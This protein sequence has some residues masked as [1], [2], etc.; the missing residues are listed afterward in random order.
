MSPRPL[1][2]KSLKSKDPHKIG[3]GERFVGHIIEVVKAAE[4][5][6]DARGAE[7]LAAMGLPASQLPRLKFLVVMAA[8]IHDWGKSSDHFQGMLW[9]TRT[10]RQLVRHEALSFL[11]ALDDD[12]PLKAWLQPCF[13]DEV[14]YRIAAIAAAGHHRKFTDRTFALENAGAGD[15]IT[16]LL[17]HKNFASML[18]FGKTLGLVNIPVPT[19]DWELRDDVFAP[20]QMRLEEVREDAEAVIPQ[21]DYRLLGLVKAMVICA[22]VAGSMM[23]EEHLYSNDL[24]E[25]LA[26]RATAAQLKNIAQTKLSG[27]QPHAFQAALAEMKAPISMVQ[28]GCGSGKTVGAYLWAAQHAG[29]QIWFTYPTTGTATEGYRGYLFEPDIDAELIHGRA[30]VDR[31]L[32]ELTEDLDDDDNRGQVRRDALDAWGRM[33]VACTVDTVLGLIQNQRK[34]LYNWPGIAHSAII[35]DEIHAYDDRL[36]GALLRF[37]QACPGIPALLMT[38]SLPTARLSA[39]QTVSQEVHGLKLPILDGPTHLEALPRYVLQADADPM[40]AA[41]DCLG[42]GGKVL[43][44]CNTVGRCRAA[45]DQASGQGWPALCYHSRFRYED[46]VARHSDVVGSFEKQAAVIAVT[47]QVCEMSLD[48][49]ADL[50]V[51][52]LA[53]IPA[54]IQRLGRLN[55]KATPGCSP[56]P[57]IVIEPDNRLPYAEDQLAEARV[58]VAALGGRVVS[59]KDLIDA[60]SQSNAPVPP[61]ESAWLDLVSKTE[62]GNLRESSPSLTVLLRDDLKRVQKHRLSP[63]RFALPMSLPRG[64]NW[65]KWPAHNNIPSPP[66]DLIEYDPLRGAQWRK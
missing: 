65:R 33:A 55:R 6:V 26:Q 12:S 34:G 2:A 60:W 36:F 35:F 5:L 42:Q 52:E 39:L 54:L 45:F 62:I 38:A 15:S 4:M 59:Q 63:T 7:S 24:S 40:S 1:L 22:D 44:V 28:A 20:L 43:W 16:C 66:P 51:T 31:E 64:M 32:L 37:L 30:W 21:E 41:A 17:S 50:M 53:P 10:A 57:F 47:T 9:G 61:V 48:L 8:F 3:R 18:K 27:H 29:R 46:R 23:P 13:D 14:D 58:W 56:K 19:Q 11:L 49:S 25:R